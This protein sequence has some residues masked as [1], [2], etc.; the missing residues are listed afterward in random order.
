MT[1]EQLLKILPEGYEKAC[2]DTKAMSRKRGLQ[3]EKDLLTLC[4]FYGYN[5][6]L[7]EVQSYAKAAGIY[8]IS[9]VGFMKR[10]SRC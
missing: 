9:D 10:F 5:H 2:W 7:I 8:D 6:S 4:L 3:S 1:R